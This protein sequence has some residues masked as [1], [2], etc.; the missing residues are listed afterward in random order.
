MAL[1]TAYT[2]EHRRILFTTLAVATSL[3]ADVF[4]F[5][6]ADPAHSGKGP[7]RAGKVCVVAWGA[8]CARPSRG[9]RRP[10]RARPAR[11]TGSA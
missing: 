7:D 6:L 8:R 2:T 3:L 11:W 9:S 4:W 5:M 1:L 10:L